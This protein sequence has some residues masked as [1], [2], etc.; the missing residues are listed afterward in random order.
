MTAAISLADRNGAVRAAA[1]SWKRAGAIDDA[2]LAAVEAAC[3]DD[4]HGVG[5][6]LRV[7]LFLFT[8]LS[9]GGAFGFVVVAIGGGASENVLPV[10]GFLFGAGLITAADYQISGLRRWRGG[11]EAAAS[12]AGIGFLTGFAYWLLYVEA[13]LPDDRATA[14][15]LLVAALLLAAA[16]WRW[17][18]AVYAGMAM[19]ALLE[20]L[21]I[22]PF[23][24]LLWILL[25]LAAAPPLA[26]LAAS[27]RLPPAHRASCTAA[28]AVGLAG[29]YVAVH[30]GSLDFGLVE[31]FSHG[32]QS[33][34][35]PRS[36]LVRWLSLAATAL[37][38][39]VYLALG[40]RSRRWVFL[41]LG[42]GTATASLVTL[43]WYVHLAP[44]WIVL[45]LGGAALVAAVFG[46]R[47]HLDSGPEKE[48]HGFTAEPLF[49]E[50]GRRRM[51]EA[52]AAVL[53]LSPEARPVHQEPKLSGGG[54]SFGGGGSSSDF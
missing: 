28:L 13:G 16:A 29:L 36:G 8:L 50:I 53:S 19:A 39:F 32:W 2:S 17:G 31:L 33:R 24:R 14:G 51:L 22:L 44:L 26:R 41:I 46:A 34:S 5:P 23:G 6:V 49:D 10:L 38:P 20:S 42:L 43:R 37:V 30:Y 54:G 11:I 18:Y 4:R 3:P 47:R 35:V 9:I 48:R 15:M 52:G 25:P 21:A 40:L 12:L 27:V 45:T 1:R 7:L